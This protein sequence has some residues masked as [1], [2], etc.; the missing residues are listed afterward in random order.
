MTINEH[1]TEFAGRRV[2]LWEPGEPLPDPAEAFCRLALSWDELDN[3]GS[4]SQKLARFLADPASRAVE[5]LV[6]GV[7][8][9]L[10]ADKDEEAVDIIAALVAA[11]DQLPHLRA[12]FVGDIIVE[13]SEI[14][15]IRQGD[16]APLLAAY[17]QLEHFG[18]RGGDGLTLGALRHDALRT[19]IV[20]TGGLPGSVAREVA[21]AE[22]PNLRHLELWLGSENYGNDTTT[23][24][25][26]PILAGDRFPALDYLGLRDS[27]RADKVAAAVAVAPVLARIGTLDLSLGT[28]TDE[29]AAALLASPAVA[30]LRKLDI[31][32]HFC[33]D[34]LIAQLAAL[35]PE[36]DA[37][38]QQEVDEYDGEFYRYAAVTE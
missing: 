15:W 33:S 8:G 35:P 18:V 27:E 21:A 31:H 3:G 22:L 23:D 17:P 29:G 38:E 14:S 16:H 6:V 1:L 10:I 20:Q 13:E 25:L 2:V 4:W 9:G 11:R 26:A 24:D 34:E 30:R 37:S 32:H 5:G 28:L 19:L 7:W 36:L 12:L